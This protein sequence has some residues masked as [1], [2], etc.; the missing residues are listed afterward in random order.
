MEK[1]VGRAMSSNIGSVKVLEKIGLKF[2]KNFDFDGK[3]GVI[4]SIEK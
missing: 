4:Y 2:E 1:I 3:D